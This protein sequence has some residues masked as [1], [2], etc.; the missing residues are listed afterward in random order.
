M[1]DSL[2]AI[3]TSYP[4]GGKRGTIVN[5][6]SVEQSVPARITINTSSVDQKGDEQFTNRMTVIRSSIDKTNR[7]MRIGFRLELYEGEKQPVD[8][9]VLSRIHNALRFISTRNFTVTV[10]KGA[11]GCNNAASID[12]RVLNQFMCAM[13]GNTILNYP[14]RN[15]IINGSDIH[16]TVSKEDFDAVIHL[17]QKPEE[18][19][20]KLTSSGIAIKN[21]LEHNFPDHKSIGQIA[22]VIGVD[23]ET[24]R[25]TIKGRKDRNSVSLI[26]AGFVEEIGI[27]SQE[28][29][30]VTGGSGVE[31]MKPIG[32]RIISKE[33]RASQSANKTVSDDLYSTKKKPGFV[34][35]EMSD[36]VGMVY[37]DQ[38]KADSN[39]HVHSVNKEADPTHPTASNQCDAGSFSS[40]TTT[41]SNQSNQEEEGGI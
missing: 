13:M 29:E 31:Y 36:I 6:D 38:E 12:V 34:Q 25:T 17:Y 33:Y 28:K 26:D 30:I 18:Y 24:V 10:P 5:G 40:L 21:Y 22:K 4:N 19:L 41:V 9:E 7:E 2:K 15:P 23:P 39:V 14:N 11:I 37:W 27:T 20:L 8:K 16:I 3:I 1:I 35:T 32:E